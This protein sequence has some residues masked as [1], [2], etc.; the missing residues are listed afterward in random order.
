MGIQIANN[1][2]GAMGLQ[3]PTRDDFEDDDDD[4]DDDDDE[5][6][7]GQQDGEEGEV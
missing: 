3:L 2:R 6:G 1:A 5:N 7:D 4:D